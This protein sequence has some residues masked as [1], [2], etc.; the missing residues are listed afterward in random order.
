ML[1]NGI[2]AA[3]FSRKAAINHS[4]RSHTIA[5][6]LKF[7]RRFIALVLVAAVPLDSFAASLSW[8]DSVQT[9]AIISTSSLFQTQALAGRPFWSGNI[10]IGHVPPSLRS[11]AFA[12]ASVLLT[13]GHLQVMAQE[14]QN[15]SELVHSLQDDSVAWRPIAKAIVHSGDK[16]AEQKMIEALA[17]HLES[18][19]EPEV[20]IMDFLVQNKNPWVISFARSLIDKYLPIELSDFTRPDGSAGKGWPQWQEENEKKAFLGMSILLR[21]DPPLK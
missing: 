14:T 9:C 17:Q 16:A 5:T 4:Y 11:I 3:V 21:A 20:G 2:D 7:F 1:A 6:Y 12:I 15:L 8:R 18:S 10:S 19:K 13:G